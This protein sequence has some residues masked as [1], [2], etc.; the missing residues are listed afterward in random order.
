MPGGIGET[1]LNDAKQCDFQG[2][3]QTAELDLVYKLDLGFFAVAP[4]GAQILDGGDD[5]RLVEYRRAQPPDQA[6]RLG[7]AVADQAQNVIQDFA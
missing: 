3:G 7:H 4:V 2:S 1:F 6:P 5:A